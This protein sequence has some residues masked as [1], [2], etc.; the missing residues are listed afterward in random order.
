MSRAILNFFYQGNGLIIVGV[1]ILAVSAA[2]LARFVATGLQRIL[3]RKPTFYRRPRVGVFSQVVQI[4]LIAI[5]A[6]LGLSVAFAGST[7][8]SYQA[9]TRED[10]VAK[11]EG[12]AWDAEKRLMVVRL[13]VIQG[14][15]TASSQTYDLYGDQWEVNA[16]ILKWSPAANLV[17][18]HTAYRLNMIKGIYQD[19]DA[20]SR[21][22]HMAYALSAHPDWVWGLL[23]RYGERFPLVQ[24]V[25]GNAVS[26][27][28]QP[29]EVYD[30]FVTTSGLSC[31][32]AGN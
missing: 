25:Y 6:L 11:V 17:G 20:E 15:R 23:V 4:S 13:S 22:P 21:S 18:L 10:L 26:N 19:A 2:W 5:L 28:I 14:G 9:F 12:L 24:A 16:H 27:P 29:G 8:R 1:I 3:N 7:F 31:R 30:V 32:R